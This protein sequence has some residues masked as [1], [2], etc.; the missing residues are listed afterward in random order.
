MENG[1]ERELRGVDERAGRGLDDTQ[2]GRVVQA[3]REV[4]QV[5][6]RVDVHDVVECENA[7]DQVPARTGVR[8]G[9]ARRTQGQDGDHARWCQARADPA[10]QGR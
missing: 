9:D 1:V 5:G 10:R 7:R 6:R 4:R 8:R 2:V 3:E